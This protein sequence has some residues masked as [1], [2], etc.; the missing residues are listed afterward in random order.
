MTA[1]A[2]DLVLWHL[3]FSDMQK[4]GVGGQTE[5]VWRWVNARDYPRAR[6]AV[7]LLLREAQP[8]EPDLSARQSPMP[9]PEDVAPENGT[10]AMAMPC[11]PGR[12]PYG[13]RRGGGTWPGLLLPLRALATRER[14]NGQ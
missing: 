5:G 4:L 9:V 14:S 2:Y 11:P 8:E 6:A 12:G 7:D 1:V 10:A 13:S 3:L